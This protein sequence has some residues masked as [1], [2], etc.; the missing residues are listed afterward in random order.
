MDSIADLQMIGSKLIARG[1]TESDAE[2]VLGGNWLRFLR[3]H[4]PS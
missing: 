2:N 1:Y 3:K 4:L